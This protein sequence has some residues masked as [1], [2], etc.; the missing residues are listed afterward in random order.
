MTLPHRHDIRLAIRAIRNAK[1]RSLLTVLGIVIGIVAVVSIVDIS[2]GIKQQVSGQINQ[3]G[4]NLITIR[5]GQIT[6][7]NPNNIISGITGLSP[8]GNVSTLTSNDVN[9]IRFTGG[10]GQA[11]PLTSISGQ[12]TPLGQSPSSALVIGTGDQLPSILNQTMAYGSFFDSSNDSNNVAVIGQSLADSLFGQDIPLGHS[13]TFHGQSFIVVGIFNLFA[14]A[15]LSLNADF[16]NTIFIPYSIAQK[17]SNNTASIEEVLAKPSNPNDLAPVAAAINLNLKDAHGGQQDFTVLKQ[18]QSLALTSSV[19]AS[20]TDLIAVIAGISL[21]VGG[22]GIMNVTLVSVTERTREIGIRKAVGATNRQIL[23]QFLIEASVMSVSGGF[24][25]IF[26]SLVVDYI[27]R[28]STNLQPVITWQI[29]VLATAVTLIIG[30]VFGAL[31]AF[32]AARKDPIDAL[33]YE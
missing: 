9:T 17:L 7:K 24:L 29:I 32:Q 28:V 27:L 13:F 20:L 11:V 3:V 25:G 16:N 5:P 2:Q 8:F 31:P 15:P 22:V 10:V 26:F 21:L 19:L 1:G 23:S 12:V 4:K 14:S 6:E 33:R 30:I 18:S